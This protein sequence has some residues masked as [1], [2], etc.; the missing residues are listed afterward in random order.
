MRSVVQRRDQ[1]LK[2]SLNHVLTSDIEYTPKDTKSW[3]FSISNFVDGE[4]ETGSYCLRFKNEEIAAAFKT[5]LDNSLAGTAEPLAPNAAV[6]APAPARQPAAITTGDEQ[7][8]AKLQ[9]PANFYDYNKAEPCKG[10]RGC[11]PDDFVFPVTQDCNANVVHDPL[12]LT[13]P[14]QKLTIVKPPKSNQFVFGSTEPPKFSFAPKQQSPESGSL[15]GAKT[16][17][18][19]SAGDPVST[20]NSS[21]FG[22][23][24]LFGGNNGTGAAVPNGDSPSFTFA[25]PVPKSDGKKRGDIERYHRLIDFV[26]E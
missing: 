22:G 7:N 16:T 8:I 18:F 10:C 5:A 19:G 23:A 2:I 17:S 26:N 15:F 9:L 4:T 12:P 1:I 20:S 11:N 6:S 25:T 3:Q 13:H 14:T 21:I 24:S